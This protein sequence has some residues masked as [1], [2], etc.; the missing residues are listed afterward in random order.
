MNM[1]FNK[2]KEATDEGDIARLQ[3]ASAEIFNRVAM[4]LKDA[5]GV[6]VESLLC[7]LGALAGYAC[8]Y[9]VRKEMV[10]QRNTPENAVFV[11]VGTRSGESY[12]F[13][14]AL[15][16]PLAESKYSVVSL[17]LGVLKSLGGNPEDI[18]VNEIFS[19]T[20]QVV[21]SPQFGVIRTP[22]GHAP[23]D[24]PL[25]YLKFVWPALLPMAEKHCRKPEQLPILYAMAAQRA[26]AFAK[27]VLE[28]SL[29]V[30]IV[31]ESAIPMSKVNL[32]RPDKAGE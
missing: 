21:G 18:D 1:F 20:A 17:M 9:S 3:T 27:G 7:L 32:P 19:H 31:L 25:N 8:Q 13:G 5:R 16:T 15:N 6:H 28:P 23:G 24:L 2:K 22:E 29:A 14:D 10:E 11:V 12:F 26:V 30:R 4:S